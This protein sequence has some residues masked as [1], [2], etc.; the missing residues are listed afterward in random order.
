MYAYTTPPKDKNVDILIRAHGVL[1]EGIEGIELRCFK[2]TEHMFRVAA[3]II[4]I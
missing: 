2:M 3:G 4:G 1:H